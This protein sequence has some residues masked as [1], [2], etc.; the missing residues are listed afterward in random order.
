MPRPTI[1]AKITIS[2]V[3]II[4]VSIINSGRD[5][6]VTDIMKASVVPKANPFSVSAL[7]SGITPPALAYNGMPI[8]V[9]RGT[10]Y[11]WLAPA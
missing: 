5:K 8:K 1:E 7:T 10:A 4:L 3:F 11:H 6:A 9:A 2:L